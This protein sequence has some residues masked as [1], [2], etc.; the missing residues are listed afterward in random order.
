MR[1]ARRRTTIAGVDGLAPAERT[2]RVIEI[3]FRTRDLR[4]RVIA[5]AL[6]DDPV[7]LHGALA[8]ALDLYSPSVALEEVFVPAVSA[9]DRVG[10]EAA[11]RAGAA[12]AA[13][14]RAWRRVSRRT[15]R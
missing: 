9:L 14:L 1:A 13:H 5:G 12:I 7:R 15:A 3:G 6:Q 8:A 11:D 10:V 4:A 2:G